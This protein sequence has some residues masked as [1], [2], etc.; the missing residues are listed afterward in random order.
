MNE[1]DE[2]ERLRRHLAAVTAVNRQLKAQLDGSGIRA[3]GLPPSAAPAN[4][5]NRWDE[6]AAAGELAVGGAVLQLA[7]RRSR[8]AVAW[9][10][11][12]ARSTPVEVAIGA[13]PGGESVVLEGNTRR[14]VPSGLLF[15]GLVETF[16][17]PRQLSAKEFGALEEGPPVE[18]HESAS[19]G[20]FVLV[21]GRRHPVR[22]FPLPHPLP[23]AAVADLPEGDAVDVAA[24]STARRHVSVSGQAARVARVLQRR[25]PDDGSSVSSAGRAIARRLQP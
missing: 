10:G 12:L 9:V 15:A 23:D 3:I 8:R 25:L 13:G 2:V 7:Q 17:E 16:G 6:S 21:G 22:G 5:P 4:G 19:G 1:S 20:P 18:L 14:R 11:S 24:A